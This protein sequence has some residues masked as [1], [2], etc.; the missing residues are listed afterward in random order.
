MRPETRLESAVFQLTPTRT[1]CDLVVVANG[2]KEKVASGLLN[3]FV[4]HLKVAQEQIAK[5]GYSI[6]LEPAAEVD[7][8]W[9][10]R[11]TVERFVR[12][13]STPEV[14][15]RVSTIESEILQIVDA[16]A[17]Q[18]ND[19]LGLRSVEDH[20]GKLVDGI[21]GRKTSYDPDADKALVPYEQAGTQPIPPVQNHGATQEENSK[22]QL[23]RVLETR[24]TVLRKEQAMAFARAVAAG[25]DIDNLVYLIMFA[26]HFGASRLM[27]ACTHFI[28]LWKQ[29]HE[30]GQWIEV[31]PEAMSAR[32][33]F[34]PFNP[35]GIMFMGD[36]MK[37]TMQ[38]M[39]LSNGDEN[40]DDASKADLRASQH[41]GAPH[42]LNHGPYQS[43]YPPWAMHP[44]YTMQ[45]LPYYP[46]MNPYYPT[47][48]PPM[49]DTRYQHSERRVSKK[50]SGS[51]DS[52]TSDDESDKS[53]SEGEASYGNR[54]YKKD[55]RTGKKKPSVVVIRNINVTSK[56]HGSLGNESQTGS[57]VASEDSDDTHT[58]SRKKKNKSSSLKKKD[59]RKI[60]LESAD[61][62][63]RDEV[64]YGQD[65][66][67][68][69]W[70]VFQSFLLRADE[71]TIDH[72]TDL[73]AREKELRPARR[74]DSR[75]IDDSILSAGRYSAGADEHNMTGFEM[76]NG[77]VRPRQMLSGDELMMSGEGRSFAG[78]G[79]KEIEAGG[80]R[81]R[82]ETSDD[83]MIYGQE[84]SMDRGG[85]LDPLA[86]AQ[87][88]NPTVVEKDV[89]G[90]ADESFMIPLRSTSVDNLGPESRTAI[91]IDVE[92]P[93]TVQKI[94]DAKA[95]GQ[96]FYEPDELMPERACEEISFGYDPTMDYDSQMQSHPATMV[97][98]A[99][100]E[101][102][103]LS[104]GDEV[105]KPG[106]D[107]RL[108]NSQGSLDKQK[109]DVSM[110]R[111]S[112]SKGQMT[113]AQKRA[114][115]LRAYKAD[116]QKAKKEQEEEQIKRL[117]RLKLERQKRI[118]ARS[119]PSNVSTTPH[120]PKVK[121]SPKVSP[122][123]YKS[124]KFSDAEPASSSPLRK[125]PAK[126]TPG[127]GPLKT[128]KASKLNYN[129]DTVS[130]STSSLTDMRKEK[131]G[132]AESSSE[133]LRKLAEPKTNGSTDHP[134][135]KSASVDH[136]RRRSMP[137]D[138]QKKKISAI[139]Q[140]DQSK[141]AALPELKVKFQQAPAVVKN[142]V[143]A[144]EKK[145]VAAGA[146]APTTETAGVM[147]TN[148][149]ISRVNSCD[150]SLVVEKTVVILE[151]EVVSTPP[152]IMHSG[153]NAAKETSSDDRTEKPNPEVEYTSIRAPP[154]PVIPPEA[155]SPVSNGS[156]D[157]GNTY[158]VVTECRKDEPERPTLAAE[159]KPYQAPFARVT[160]LENASDNSSLP[161]QEPDS[162]VHA[163]SIKARVHE[164]VYTVS[165][166]SHE[167]NEKPRSK[168]PKGFRK[169]L[170]F[171][172]KSHTSALTEGA[173]DSD[174]SSVDDAPAR[175][176]S[177]LKSLISQEDSGA[178]SKASRS[179]SLLSPFRS[180]HKVIVL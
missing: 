109:K 179:F 63:N 28:E 104:T 52:E 176:G 74:K 105:K 8:P 11:G 5:G 126:T 107:N 95:A 47:P 97:E 94:S 56:R 13:V 102:A 119:S 118:A 150:D 130:K 59:A 40:G 154:S 108:R 133:R 39:S 58:K 51:K 170:K 172:R 48:Y 33:E 66:D 180:K 36:N 174:M 147:K 73:F 167:V 79:I 65:G 82:R 20:N 41:S 159:E 178:S 35:S 70:N 62:Y 68:G 106:K 25:F 14:L 84:K 161:V 164:P 116:L 171:A 165:V 99:R 137:Q 117:E 12:F 127:T 21:E 124:S 43:A 144:K 163:D 64:P 143:A 50:H 37:Q 72:D 96:L 19:S 16:I 78:D 177:M 88:K 86:E 148:G 140:L 29:K 38:T 153:R 166:E 77:R 27:K 90:I 103:S 122:S 23:L 83:F 92:L 9:F 173:M 121:P 60:I 53:S 42:E 17:I 3:P 131:S 101:D 26:E 136:P 112:S 114:Q 81:Y 158:E 152:I 129:A 155:E 169:L 22:A 85:S 24:K 100:V 149:S 57:D 10:T 98:D 69:N 6:T 31:E 87:Y 156:D 162:H 55:K 71:K 142:V 135:S 4:A 145:E 67:Q 138:T 32:S 139:M 110:R 34:S 54:S 49:D 80:A 7:A 160:S 1:R 113:D 134:N 46:G 93:S 120:Q 128:A 44:P 123:T 61:E 125:L 132:R 89:H 115:N 45:G 30:T 75:S 141:S 2:R 76:E 91:D 111:L 15:E 168:E 146:R 151:N 175:D 157:P 18:V